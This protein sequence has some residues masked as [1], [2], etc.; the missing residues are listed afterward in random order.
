METFKVNTPALDFLAAI[1]TTANNKASKLTKNP[2]APPP[3]VTGPHSTPPDEHTE[4]AEHAGC[5]SG[6]HKHPGEDTNGSISGHNGGRG[7]KRPLPSSDEMPLSFSPPLKEISLGEISAQNQLHLLNAAKMLATHAAISVDQRT[8]LSS[9]LP[10]P[11]NT[12]SNSAAQLPP[13]AAPVLAAMLSYGVNAMSRSS[14]PAITGNA[15]VALSLATELR[16]AS[17]VDPVAPPAA[18][19]TGSQYSSPGP[20]SDTNAPDGAKSDVASVPKRTCGCGHAPGAG[21]AGLR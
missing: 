18:P 15:A 2:A 1:V 16:G 13:V 14:T 10:T 6:E 5:C 7:V 11:D 3:P 4:G 17:A 12:S 19:T 8:P 20:S 9:S 21:D